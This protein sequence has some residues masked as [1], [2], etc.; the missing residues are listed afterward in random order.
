MITIVIIW[1]I[2]A[3]ICYGCHR[4]EFYLLIKRVEKLEQIV[5]G[6]DDELDD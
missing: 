6:E 5:Y 3:L 2:L 1:G 4:F